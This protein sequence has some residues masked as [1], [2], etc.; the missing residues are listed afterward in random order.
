MISQFYSL[1]EKCSKNHYLTVNG[2]VTSK[3]WVYCITQC[4]LYSN[5]YSYCVR[6]ITAKKA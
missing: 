2:Q 4:T 1:K 6:A 3:E 5:S